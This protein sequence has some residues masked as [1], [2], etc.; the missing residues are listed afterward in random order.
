VGSILPKDQLSSLS[1]GKARKPRAKTA[2]GALAI[3]S[4]TAILKDLLENGIIRYSETFNIGDVT[5]SALPPDRIN[6]GAQESNQINL[7]MYRVSPYSGLSRR[8]AGA[9][10]QQ[11]HSRLGLELSYLVTAYGM[12][13]FHAEI[14]LGCAMQLLHET[15]LL[16]Q[17]AIRASLQSGEV[18]RS[19]GLQ[20]L[21]RAALSVSDLADQVDQ[22]KVT[23]QFLSFE[24]MSK[25]WSALQARYRPSVTYQASAVIIN[26]RG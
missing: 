23:P 15:P 20:S 4:V 6:M 5:V 25:L 12:Q 19:S 18:K 1:D 16:T 17:E 10:P 13:D 3:A 7:F 21:A 2:S 24:E 8:V 22:I 26:G 14:L 9:E 11:H